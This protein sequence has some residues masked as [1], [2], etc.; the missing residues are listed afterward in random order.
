MLAPQWR[1]E[2][3]SRPGVVQREGRLGAHAGALCGEGAGERR[4]GQGRHGVRRKEV[5]AAVVHGGQHLGARHLR[6]AVGRL[7]THAPGFLRARRELVAKGREA[8]L[9]LL[10]VPGHEDVLRG[11]QD[12]VVA[13][14]RER[15]VEAAAQRLADRPVDHVHGR[16]LAGHDV[17][18]VEH[19]AWCGVFAASSQ[20]QQVPREALLAAPELDEQGLVGQGAGNQQPQAFAHLHRALVGQ[21]Q[22]CHRQGATVGADNEVEFAAGQRAEAVAR[23]VHDAV[24]AHRQGGQGNGGLPLRVVLQLAGRHA[25]AQGPLPQGLRDVRQTL[26]TRVLQVTRRGAGFDGACAASDGHGAASSGHGDALCKRVR[27]IVRRHAGA[28]RCLQGEQRPLCRAGLWRAVQVAAARTQCVSLVGAGELGVAG[29][30]RFDGHPAE[31]KRARGAARFA[32]L[33]GE[34]GCDAI[35][36]AQAGLRRGFGSAGRE[37][38]FEVTVGVQRRA[39]RGHDLLARWRAIETA[40]AVKPVGVDRLAP[41]GPAKLTARHRQAEVVARVAAHPGRGVQAIGLGR[42]VQADFES[43]PLVFLDAHGAGPARRAHAPLPQQAP[44]RQQEFTGRGAEGVGAQ[45]A[46]GDFLAVGVAQD[47]LNGRIGACRLQGRACARRPAAHLVGEHLEM[48]GLLRPVHAAVGVDQGGL[49]VAFAAI[50]VGVEEIRVQRNLAIASRHDEI[51][52]PFG[53]LRQLRHAIGVGLR[54][55]ADAPGALRRVL[56]QRHVNALQRHAAARV[57]S[58][59]FE[60]A[61]E[62]TCHE[63]GVRDQKGARHQAVA[64]GGRKIFANRHQQHHQARRREWRCD[65]GRVHRIVGRG[66][67]RHAPL[68]DGFCTRATL[69][70]VAAE[71]PI[72]QGATRIAAKAPLEVHRIGPEVQPRQVLVFDLHRALAG[73]VGTHGLHGQAGRFDLGNQRGATP[74]TRRVGKRRAAGAR[75]GMRLHGRAQRQQELRL[76]GLAFG[77]PAQRRVAVGRQALLEVADDRAPLGFV[78][79]QCEQL[80]RQFQPGFQR[81]G[82]GPGRIARGVAAA[83][84]VKLV[85]QG[86]EPERRVGGWVVELDTRQHGAAARRIDARQQGGQRQR[87]ALVQLGGRPAGGIGQVRNPEIGDEVA[88]A[89]AQPRRIVAPLEVGCQPRRGLACESGTLLPGGEVLRIGFGVNLVDGP[90]FEINGPV[91]LDARARADFVAVGARVVGQRMGIE[92]A[93]HELRAVVLRPGLFAKCAHRRLVA[94]QAGAQLRFAHQRERPVLGVAGAARLLAQPGDIARGLFEF[95]LVDQLVDAGPGVFHDGRCS[96]ARQRRESQ[97]QP[98]PAYW[99]GA[100]QCVARQYQNRAQQASE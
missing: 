68:G 10:V 2:R 91:C 96:V 37:S 14:A 29:E 53:R 90:R 97:T 26:P 25:L 34:L 94:V 72:G 89:V 74:P 58:L 62:R 73:A 24:G 79:Q 41:D 42:F 61:G 86:A 100:Q 51:A 69:D 93:Q 78:V 36:V 28:R 99:H 33:V 5:Q 55:C 23:L 46:L 9:E 95:L 15:D 50:V 40:V 17:M 18:F 3:D 75:L 22:R 70:E 12:L 39:A 65:V 32:A 19:R 98:G 84:I 85:Q 31:P 6:L 67:Q 47:H 13:H 88:Q 8:E 81:R 48:Q 35:A 30:L 57:E 76:R 66:G 43:R 63:H 56:V 27:H 49:A 60:A 16:R 21:Q 38:E 64:F 1:L 52:T 92:Q 4:P 77:V 82:P 7:H 20:G 59:H 83:P 80:A 44:G 71:S 54:A 87:V 11:E 45:T